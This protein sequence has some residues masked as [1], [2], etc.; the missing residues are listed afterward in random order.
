M[1]PEPWKVT[2]LEA[3]RIFHVSILLNNLLP[4][5]VGD[6]ARVLSPSV[7]RAATLQQALVVLVAERLIDGLTLVLVAAVALPLFFHATGR[8]AVVDGL[9]APGSGAILIFAGGFLVGLLALAVA[10]RVR[11]PALRI[12]LTER[13]KSLRADALAIVQQTPAH[14]ARLVA[15]TLLAWAATFLL[16]LAVLEALDAPPTVVHPLVLATVVVLSTN[17]SMLAPAT[18]GG[19]GLFHAAA[20]APLLV[21]GHSTEVAVA[22]A[23]LVHVINTVPPMLIGAIGLGAPALSA[24]L[25]GAPV[26]R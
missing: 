9:T 10:V 12:L 16:H 1:L 24:R 5:R 18:P 15:A 7:R 25:R 22:Y 19:I 2:R 20:A 23:L 14:L 11:W 4:F 6:G 21:A 17:L 13:V 3:L 26:D 8:Q